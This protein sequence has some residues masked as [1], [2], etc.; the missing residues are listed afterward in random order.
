VDYKVK[1]FASSYTSF[2]IA[3]CLSI[4]GIP[5]LENTDYWFDPEINDY[6]IKKD[7]ASFDANIHIYFSH[8]LLDHPEEL[9][10]C[11]WSKISVLLDNEDT[12]NPILSSKYEVFNNV[13]EYLNMNETDDHKGYWGQTERRHNEEYYKN[14]NQCRLKD[15]FRWKVFF[16]PF[17][18][19]KHKG[20]RLRAKL[21]RNIGLSES[22][23][24]FD[25]I[26]QYGGWQFFESFLFN[27]V[28][29]Q[30]RL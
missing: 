8:F 28:P 20:Q 21:Q 9:D 12:F 1:F 27:S 26:T 4:L 3:E 10:N 16:D 11:D 15:A 7:D 29:I 2:A 17:K 19:I 14:I 23:N 24:Q 6:L 5:F 30:N 13:M 22:V 25:T 18:K